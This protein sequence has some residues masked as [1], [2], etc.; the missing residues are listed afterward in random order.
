MQNNFTEMLRE[1]KANEHEIR[2]ETMAFAKK[3]F[4]TDT[5]ERALRALPQ[6]RELAEARKDPKTKQTEAEKRL[7]EI[8]VMMFGDEDEDDHEQ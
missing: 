2:R 8:R 7:E 3:K 5:T 1:A 4:E 6:L